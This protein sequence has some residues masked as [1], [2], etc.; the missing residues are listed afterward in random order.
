[1]NDAQQQRATP[2]RIGGIADPLALGSLKAGGYPQGPGRPRAVDRELGRKEFGGTFPYSSTTG[3]PP[4]GAERVMTDF[5]GPLIDQL[6]SR[7]V[8]DL[9][10]LRPSA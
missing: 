6:S 9:L 2:R 4:A 3:R 7:L 10:H 5:N 1:M 8:T